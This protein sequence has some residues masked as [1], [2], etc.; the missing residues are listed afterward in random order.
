[1]CRSPL[2]TLPGH[3][4][5][6]GERISRALVRMN[7]NATRNATKASS[8][9][10]DEAP[11]GSPLVEMVMWNVA[12]TGRLCQAARGRSDNGPV[13]PTNADFLR[14]GYEAW[15]RGDLSSIRDLLDPDIEWEEGEAAPEGGIH[16][17]RDSFERFFESWLESFDEFH[18]EPVEI[19]ER[20]DHIVVVAR[21]SGRGRAS[22]VP[23]TTE[24]VHV[25]T[26]SDGRAVRWQSFTSRAAAL[27]AVGG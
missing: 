22:A 24:V 6:F 2:D 18:V 14:H 15:N 5:T 11:Q 3:H 23:I 12:K 9:G 7:R 17:G 4:G 27:A 1:M 21:Q 25:W 10:R 26:V 16:R 8:A 13:T 20:G 19:M